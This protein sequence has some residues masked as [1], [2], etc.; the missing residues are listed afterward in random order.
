MHFRIGEHVVIHLAARRGNMRDRRLE[1]DDVDA[2]DGGN[3]RQPSRR[4]AG[5][6][7]DDEDALEIRM[8]QGAN[9]PRHHLRRG[10]ANG[11]AVVLPVDDEREAI[12]AVERDRALAAVGL[13]D[14]RAARVVEQTAPVV[15][16]L[17]RQLEMSGADRGVAPHRGRAVGEAQAGGRD[18]EQRRCE[19]AL[20]R[21]AATQHHGERD[22]SETQQEAYNAFPY[23]WRRE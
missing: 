1:L 11:V 22:R 5:S 13:P 4:T 16:R 14:E 23:S 20:R 15:R 2:L 19:R 6:Q 21:S 7:T 3:L 18:A 12:R 10:V 8:K 17:Q 9:E